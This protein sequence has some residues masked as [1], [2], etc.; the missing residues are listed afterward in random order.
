MTSLRPRH[1]DTREADQGLTGATYRRD[2][3]SS[4]RHH[5]KPVPLPNGDLVTS[6]STR[7]PTPEGPAC[8]S[9]AEQGITRR[10]FATLAGATPA[11]GLAPAGTHANAASGRGARIQ[12][13][14]S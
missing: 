11:A 10:R 14:D 4:C 1:Q 8:V 6:S 13:S 9:Q 5:T 2:E 7:P 12:A 3:Q